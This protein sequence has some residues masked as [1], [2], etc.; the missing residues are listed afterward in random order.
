[1]VPRLDAAFD[2]SVS[3]GAIPSVLEVEGEV[4]DRIQRPPSSAR[5]V[6]TSQKVLRLDGRS[7]LRAGQVHQCV[8]QGGDASGP[9]RAVGLR[10]VTASDQFGPVALGFSPRHQGR[11]VAV[12]VGA[13]RLCR[14]VVSPTGRCR[15]QGVPAVQP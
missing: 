12:Q 14:P 11:E 4:V 15:M 3:Q 9:F 6:T 1:M 8:F 10:N 7:Q 5:A 2:R 13:L